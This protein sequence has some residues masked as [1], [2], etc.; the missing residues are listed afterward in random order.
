MA[1][2]P[3]CTLRPPCAIHQSLQAAKLAA[4][5]AAMAATA[6]KKAEKA[7]ATAAVQEDEE[8][9]SSEDEDD[10]PEKLL[11]EKQQAQVRGDAA[12]GCCRLLRCG[13]PAGYLLGRQG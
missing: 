1:I 8:E 13:L 3:A 10:D 7:A 2:A 12:V 11:S 4:K 9:S 5:H 6:A